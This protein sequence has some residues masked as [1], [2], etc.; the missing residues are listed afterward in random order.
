MDGWIAS[1]T[2]VT[3]AYDPLLA[4]LIAHRP[5]REEALDAIAAGLAATRIGGIATTRVEVDGHAG[6]LEDCAR[7]QRQVR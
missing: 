7:G 4:K 2:E 1:G 3:T 6:G 5:S